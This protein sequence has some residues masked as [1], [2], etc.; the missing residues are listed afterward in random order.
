MFEPVGG[1]STGADDC[2]AAALAR[3][4]AVLPT[5]P[6]R[7]AEGPMQRAKRVSPGVFEVPRRLPR[8]AVE[9]ADKLLPLST[10]ELSGGLGPEVAAL[11]R[12][13][14]AGLSSFDLLEAMAGWADPPR[15]RHQARTRPRSC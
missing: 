2:H 9:P 3:L 12:I 11:C 1:P 14:P 8:A 13:D 6:A 4:R 7:I 5:T 15:R 10:D